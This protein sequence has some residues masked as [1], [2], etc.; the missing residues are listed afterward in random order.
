MLH[1]C[2][3]K[4]EIKDIGDKTIKKK[5]ILD[6]TSHSMHGFLQTQ[7]KRVETL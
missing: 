2:F 1:N 5:S 7:V 3:N 6:L 4:K